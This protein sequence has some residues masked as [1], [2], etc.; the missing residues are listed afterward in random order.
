MACMPQAM[1]M[2]HRADDRGRTSDGAEKV[3]TKKQEYKLGSAPW[4]NL[5]PCAGRTPPIIPDEPRR[6]L[7]GKQNCRRASACSGHSSRFEAA[8]PRASAAN[9]EP[10]VFKVEGRVG[11]RADGAFRAG[12][13]KHLLAPT[14][15]RGP[16]AP[17]RR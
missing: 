10:D 11:V 6:L 8:A 9:T 14:L 5:R 3:G 16:S 13:S 7:Q 4:N 17:D 12:R 1:K 2:R 15:R